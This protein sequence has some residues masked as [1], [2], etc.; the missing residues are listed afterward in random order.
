MTIKSSTLARETSEKYFSISGIVP[1]TAL[2][3]DIK[4]EIDK[5]PSA[6]SGERLSSGTWADDNMMTLPLFNF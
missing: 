2:L 3:T 6:R 5:M 1:E 4:N